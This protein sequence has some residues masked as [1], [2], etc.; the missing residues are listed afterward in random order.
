LI[1]KE[2][3]LARK[4]EYLVERD[5]ALQ[6]FHLFSG[7]IQDVEHWLGVLDKPE[8][9]FGAGGGIPPADKTSPT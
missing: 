3:L 2:T 8:D 4:S 6:T 9:K 5:K 7:A 1:T